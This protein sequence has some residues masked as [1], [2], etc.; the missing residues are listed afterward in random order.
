MVKNYR[1]LVGLLMMASLLVFTGCGAKEAETDQPQEE[2]AVL[3]ATGKAVTDNI[4]SIAIVNGK[5]AADMEVSILPKMG[6]KVAEVNFQVGDKVRKGDVLVRLESTELQAQLQQA[7]AGLA[8]AKANYESAQA[9][10]ARTKSLFEQGAV[11][12]Q[13]L[14][15]AQTAVATG[16]PDSASA[17]VQLMEAQLANTII[18]SPADGIVAS[19]TVEVGEMASQMPVMTIVDI[20]KVKVKT[21][22]TE[23]EVNKLKLS[24]KVDVIVSAVGEEPFA[25]T[26][27]TISPAA[28][29]QS[30][31]FPITIEIPNGEHKLKPGMFAEIKLAL[32]TK[33]NVLVLSKQAVIDS[34]DKKYVYVVQD[35]KAIQTEIAT[36]VED[37]TRVEVL[38]GIKDGDDIVL[39][40]QNKLQNETPVTISG[41]K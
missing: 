4:S 26:I 38:S 21:S 11:S 36:G 33:E 7:R 8:M 16:S 10:L 25:G 1:W 20:E 6:G 5:I 37:D 23:G 41:G 39:T 13:Q 24:Q 32:E 40:G 27:V 19:R 29:S 22:V 35:N 9:N 34:G 31:T 18:K 28:D 2:K 14:E 12:Q 17:S 3:V 30:N 15:A